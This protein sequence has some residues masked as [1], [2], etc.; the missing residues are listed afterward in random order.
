MAKIIKFPRASDPPNSKTANQANL[1]N[2]R[3][4]GASRGVVNTLWT[5]LVL[6][7]PILRWIIGI[8]VFIQGLRM[9]WHWHTP[10]THAGITFLIHFAVLCALTYFVA[11]PPSPTQKRSV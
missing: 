3:I 1:F 8:D 11:N 9:W 4:G 5:V 6:V 7:W 10:G 2:A